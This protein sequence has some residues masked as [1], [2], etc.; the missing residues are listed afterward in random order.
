MN[1]LSGVIDAV[2]GV[3]TTAAVGGLD[4][5]VG[6]V[7]GYFE[8]NVDRVKQIAGGHMDFLKGGAGLIGTPIRGAAR[9]AG[10]SLSTTGA[11][12]TALAQGDL[13]QIREAYSNGVFCAGHIV[14]DTAGQQT[15]DV[16]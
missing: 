15:A 7:T 12:T 8:V 10:N 11:A 6:N 5:Q 14:S 1:L 4:D 16:F 2:K 13:S 9:L 3:A